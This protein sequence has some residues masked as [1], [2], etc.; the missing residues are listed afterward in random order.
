[1]KLAIVTDDGVNVSKHFGRAPYYLV[2][3]VE[4]SSIKEKRLVPKL[5]HG[6][7][8]HGA[9][10]QESRGPHMGS[11]QKHRAIINPISDCQVVICGGMGMGAYQSLILN[12]IRP[13][14]TNIDRAEE[15][16]D[17]YLNGRIEDHPELI[18]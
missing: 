1:M 9:H 14:I 13:I 12:G 8:H 3:E 7:F 11:D 16:I 2:V 6:Q 4:G 10:Q 15:A 17:A 18:H 5:G